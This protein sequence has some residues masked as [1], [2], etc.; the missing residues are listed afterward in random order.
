MKNQI[1]SLIA[2]VGKN[3]ELGFKNDLIWKIPNDME[4]FKKKTTGH[5]VIMGQKT[6]E[7]IGR[8]LPKRKNIILTR[9]EKYK[10]SGCFVTYSIDDALKLAGEGEVFVIGGGQIYTQMIEMADKLYLTVIDKDAP[11]DTYFPAYSDFKKTKV[12]SSG[13]YKGTKYQILELERK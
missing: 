8:P 4:F 13:E 3:R 2:A 10:A 9:D 5:S 1:I 11:A 7:S 12:L 6:Y